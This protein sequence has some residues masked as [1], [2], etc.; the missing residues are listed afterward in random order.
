MSN[1]TLL[2]LIRNKHF[3]TQIYSCSFL[4][5]EEYTCFGAFLPSNTS[6]VLVSSI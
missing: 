3:S 2:K 4:S 5:L 6:T 1:G